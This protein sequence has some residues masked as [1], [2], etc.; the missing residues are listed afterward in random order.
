[1]GVNELGP[2]RGLY[3]DDTNSAFALLSS[4]VTDQALD[5]VHIARAYA[6]HWQTTTPKRGYPGS[7]QRVMAEVLKGTDIRKTGRILFADGSFANG[8]LITTPS[9]Q[10]SSRLTLALCFYGIGGAM[11]IA[12]V[13]LAFRNS[14]AAVMRQAVEMAIIS[15]HVHPAA[16]EAAFVQVT[17]SERQDVHCTIQLVGWCC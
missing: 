14:G 13:G 6:Y 1:M 16:I 9:C 8:N 11:R 4:L 10:L 17:I 2:R 5:P 15:S 3:T 12:P 7:A